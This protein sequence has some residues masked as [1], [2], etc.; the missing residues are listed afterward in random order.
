MQDQDGLHG[1]APD[2]RYA[3]EFP[4]FSTWELARRAVA[5]LLGRVE[6]R[7]GRLE[8]RVSRGRPVGS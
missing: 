5:E 6:D 1:Q 4:T 7:L 3:P 2:R 8:D